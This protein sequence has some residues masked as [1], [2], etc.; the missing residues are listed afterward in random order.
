[1]I[2]PT[3]FKNIIGNNKTDFS[4]SMTTSSNIISKISKFTQAVPKLITNESELRTF[5]D[6]MDD[7]FNKELME[8]YS[9]LCN[10]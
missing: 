2:N 3:T 10:F 8:R 5:V 4:H 6:G 7:Y 1:M 9:N